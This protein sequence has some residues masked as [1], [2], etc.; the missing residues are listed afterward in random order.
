MSSP[1]INPKTGNPFP[2]RKKDLD[3]LMAIAIH[4]GAAGTEHWTPEK[5]IE[6][7]KN[8]ALEWQREERKAGRPGQLYAYSGLGYNYIIFPD[9]SFIADVPLD[10]IAWSAAG[11]N[12]ITINICFAG[13]Y[14]DQL[15]SEAALKT[16]EQI[17]AA[18]LKER[19]QL[20]IIG[21]RDAVKFSKAA[22]PTACPGNKLY[23]YLPTLEHRARAYVH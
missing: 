14:T 15:P 3:E 10:E 1:L 4:H 16:G 17:I 2:S 20:K 7:R 12:S 9:G 8:S 11:V 6:H 21:H 23:S 13:D 22:T 19:P 18:R 5:F